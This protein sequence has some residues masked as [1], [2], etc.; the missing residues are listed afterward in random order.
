ML[1]HPLV[2]VGQRAF[3]WLPYAQ[4]WRSGFVVQGG[5]GAC[6][7]LLH[8]ARRE[9]TGWTCGAGW[10]GSLFLVAL[11]LELAGWACGAGW[12]WSLCLA[13]GFEARVGRGARSA[14]LCVGGVVL[15]AWRN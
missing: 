2:R 11:R 10:S 1:V 14:L 5:R 9:L 15:C 6:F 12:P 4:S 8:A 13:S 7:L 3:F